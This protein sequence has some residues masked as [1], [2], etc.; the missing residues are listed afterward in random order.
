MRIF[1][2]RFATTQLDRQ[3]EQAAVDALIG[4]AEAINS[5]YIPFTTQHDPRLP[6]VG[7]IIGARVEEA[8]DGHRA[9]AG[10]VQLW[11]ESDSE[12]QFAGDGRQLGVT[13]PSKLSFELGVDL[14]AQRELGVAA[15]AEI[16]RLAGP[17]AK[18]RY[19]AKKGLDT[20]SAIVIGAG[21]FAVSGIAHGFLDRLG[22]DIYEA[23][24]G[25][26]RIAAQPRQAGERLV[27]FQCG[28]E[29]PSGTVNVDLI[30]TNPSEGSIAFLLGDG[31]RQ[32]DTLVRETIEDHPRVARIV[33][34]ID[35]PRVRLL[36]WVRDDGVPTPLRVISDTQLATY[37]GLSMGGV[38]EYVDRERGV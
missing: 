35:G 8:G 36:Y 38:A 33:A 10:I 20:L 1:E 24:K 9:L 26:L 30:S 15:L 5:H 21:A 34:Q 4:M 3:G 16:A 23:L 31:L 19:H 6:P 11:D 13:R 12:E 25:R 18:P 22:E 17:G 29:G 27:Q 14:S 32:L 2:G 7:R 37:G 28:V